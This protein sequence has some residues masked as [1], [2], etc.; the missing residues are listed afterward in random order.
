VYIV[1]VAIVAL[2][3]IG[4]RM[5]EI[6]FQGM[7]VGADKMNRALGNP[8]LQGYSA[9]MYVLV[10]L[11]VMATAGLIP[12]MLERG[13]A[14]FYLSK[15]IS[16]ARLLL[17]RLAAIWIVYGA[18]MIAAFVFNYAISAALYGVFSFKILYVVAINLLVL[19]IWLT[20]TA[21]AGVVTGSTGQSIMIAFS[22]W[23]LQKILQFHELP[24]QFID[25]KAVQYVI[26]GLYYVF[27]KTG[28]ISDLTGDLIAGDAASWMPL[29]TSL[30]FAGALTLLTAHL[31]K[32]KDY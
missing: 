16:R 5:I 3:T 32:R 22:V 11:T 19:A 10:F 8:M 7:T 13:R 6:H 24:R 23:L 14:D 30:L 25:S 15:P 21:F 26:D 1:V 2:V 9:Y 17:S 31:F 28:Q 29:Y 18:I 20:V 12:A 4:S 27:P